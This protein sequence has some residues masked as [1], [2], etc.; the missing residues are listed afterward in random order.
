M[1]VCVCMRVRALACDE[2][3]G[4]FSFGICTACAANGPNEHKKCPISDQVRNFG[5]K[6]QGGNE[7]I[8]KF[9]N[10]KIKKK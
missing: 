10:K 2:A 4:R 5:R 8:L 3:T 7:A 9:G 6:K 1:C